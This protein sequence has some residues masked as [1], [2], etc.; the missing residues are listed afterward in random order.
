MEN[1][2][3]FNLVTKSQ[4]EPLSR[5]EKMELKRLI[6]LN[7]DLKNDAHFVE[8]FWNEAEFSM[9]ANGDYVYGI[10]SQEINS[11]KIISLNSKERRFF[12]KYGLLRMAVVLLLV[13]VAGGFGIFIVSQFQKTSELAE[14]ENIM[15]EKSIPS[16]Q[17]LRIFLPDGSK[18]WLNA[19]S[20]ISYP[21]KFVGSTR[22]VT[23]EGEAFFEVVENPEKPFIVRSGNLITTALGTSF[24]VK[25]YTNDSNEEVALASGKVLVELDQEQKFILDPGTA[26]RYQKG[27]KS[28]KK[29]DKSVKEIIAWKDGILR[30]ENDDLN[31]VLKKLSRWYGVEFFMEKPYHG[32]AWK[33]SGWFENDYLNNVLES[34]SFTQDFEYAINNDKVTITFKPN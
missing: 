19:A 32:E 29:E 21:E 13:I 5:S 14:V 3:F 28:I 7:P 31:T 34:I 22:N 10:I 4:T 25:N 11:E 27:D 18:V 23:L 16:G 20:K 24:N 9:E 6:S 33:Y 30:F 15:I 2:R 12:N 17:K 26:V 1:R 8:G